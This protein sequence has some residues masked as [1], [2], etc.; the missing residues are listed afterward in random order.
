M[1]I[2]KTLKEAVAAGDVPG[3]VAAAATAV[4]VAMLQR[5]EVTAG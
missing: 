1:D 4:L 2:A 3:V 5:G